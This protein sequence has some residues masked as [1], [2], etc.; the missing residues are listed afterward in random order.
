MTFSTS[1]L[2]DTIRLMDKRL[3]YSYIKSIFL[4]FRED[5]NSYFRV[6]LKIT[7]NIINFLI[8]KPNLTLIKKPFFLHVDLIKN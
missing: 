8:Y 7:K 1:I 2:I 5:E 3:K 4:N 6:G